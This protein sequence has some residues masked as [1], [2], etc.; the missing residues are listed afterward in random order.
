MSISFKGPQQ[1]CCSYMIYDKHILT[2]VN[3]PHD[4]HEFSS[5]NVLD[6]T[7]IL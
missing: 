7:L 4:P 5:E 2:H 6:N 1:D 3:G